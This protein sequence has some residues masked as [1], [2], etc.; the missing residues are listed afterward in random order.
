VNYL[1]DS[2]MLGTNAFS[3]KVPAGSNFVINV[4]A[5]TTNAICGSHTLEVLNL[6]CPPPRLRIAKDAAPGKVRVNWS[7]AYPGWNLQKTGRIPGAFSNS[8]I[9]PA[10]VGSRYVQTNVVTATNEFYRLQK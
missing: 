10:I 3:F 7:T 1:G 2:G 9:A 4:V 8:A 6:P 5:R